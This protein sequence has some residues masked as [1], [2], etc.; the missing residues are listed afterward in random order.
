MYR[1]KGME[2][3]GQVDKKNAEEGEI[4]VR[5]RQ[6]KEQA[7]GGECIGRRKKG[8]GRGRLRRKN[9]EEGEIRER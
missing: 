5:G 7:E 6:R 1:K 8:R 4:R 2:R 3:K 9:A